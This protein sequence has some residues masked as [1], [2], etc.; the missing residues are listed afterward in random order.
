MSLVDDLAQLAGPKLTKMQALV[1]SMTDDE[2][3]ALH[4]ACLSEAQLKDIF[5][6]LKRNGYDVGRTA[7][8]EYRAGLRESR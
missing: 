6:A 8:G 4:A 3:D 5:A 2:R 1:A 7:L